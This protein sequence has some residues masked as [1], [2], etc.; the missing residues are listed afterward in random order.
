[1]T[2]TASELIKIAK[3]EVSP[4]QPPVSPKNICQYVGNDSMFA[5]KCV[6]EVEISE[7]F[8][9]LSGVAEVIPSTVEKFKNCGIGQE[10]INAGKAINKNTLSQ[11]AGLKIFF[12]NPPNAILLNP[13]ATNEAINTNNKGILLG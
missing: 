12:P 5:L 1:M 3:A 4:K 13:I 9:K 8:I 7:Y 6:A 10:L 2:L 11:R